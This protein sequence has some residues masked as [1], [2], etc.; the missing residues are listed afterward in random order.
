MA[1]QPTTTTWLN[2]VPALSYNQY[3]QTGLT[4]NKLPET[5]RLEYSG[6]VAQGFP[7]VYL[8]PPSDF[9]SWTRGGMV[10]LNYLYARNHTPPTFTDTTTLTFTPG[11]QQVYSL[12]V[13][14]GPAPSSVTPAASRTP[15]CNNMYLLAKWNSLITPPPQTAI[16]PAATATIPPP[17]SD[18]GGGAAYG[19][20]SVG[21]LAGIAAGGFVLA[22]IIGGIVAL[23]YRRKKNQE[24]NKAVR[25]ALAN[26]ANNNNNNT[27][28][29]Q[30]PLPPGSGDP[31]VLTIH[32]LPTPIGIPPPMINPYTTFIDPS[33]MTPQEA[34]MLMTPVTMSPYGTLNPAF[35]FYMEEPY[36]Q[37]SGG[38][39][40]T[41]V[42]PPDP[43]TT[44]P[45][46]SYVQ[47]PPAL[48]DSM[49]IG[50]VRLATG[51]EAVL[52]P[53]SPNTGSASASAPGSGANS[54]QT[55]GS[56]PNLDKSSGV[57]MLK[58]S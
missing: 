10:P 38:D 52:P 35:G 13:F 44:T 57:V 15:D 51:E 5:L 34:G 50:G 23:V 25:E 28:P 58:K 42:V 14:C 24:I 36:K 7:T 40:Y 31:H 21:A 49:S 43:M 47:P 37:P 2:S 19:G 32:T 33:K 27:Y 45:G 18:T 46:G 3:Y 8:V 39:M 55:R 26:R 30:Q 6:T 12:F 20:L 48:V 53:I 16:P 9:D 11:A 4:I 22:L 56:Q 41:W 29:P 17:P 1:A 54:V